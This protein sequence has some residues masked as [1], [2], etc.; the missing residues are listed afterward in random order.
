[1]LLFTDRNT[2]K[3]GHH[4][5]LQPANKRGLSGH[6]VHVSKYVNRLTDINIKK[7]FKAVI[8]KCL[9]RDICNT[10]LRTSVARSTHS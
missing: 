9:S 10:S 2:K 4:I 6:I 3:L 8:K 1:M 7:I 5:G